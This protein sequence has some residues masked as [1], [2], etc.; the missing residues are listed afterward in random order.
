MASEAK[1]VGKVN[2]MKEIYIEKLIINCNVGESGDKLTKAS[3]VVEQL[4]GQAPIYG[5]GM[6]ISLHSIFIFI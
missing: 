4:T 5:R 2:K 6:V 3:R 1:K